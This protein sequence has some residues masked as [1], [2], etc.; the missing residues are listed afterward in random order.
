LSKNLPQSPTG[1]GQSD[2]DLAEIMVDTL[3]VVSHFLLSQDWGAQN[4]Q[5]SRE[6]LSIAISATQALIN[7]RKL[8]GG[9]RAKARILLT[10]LE[11]N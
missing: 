9:A 11:G 10:F 3:T 5:I 8:S 7:N 2:F 6:D 4:G 1:S